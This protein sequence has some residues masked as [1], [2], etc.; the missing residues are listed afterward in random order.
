MCSTNRQLS[1]QT[2]EFNGKFIS[3][4]LSKKIESKKVKIR[5]FS[6]KEKKKKVKIVLCVLSP[7]NLIYNV[8]GNLY[9][10]FFE[11]PQ[12]LNTKYLRNDLKD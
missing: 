6:I 1:H 8:F 12:L 10:S 4:L 2:N 7:C 5:K 9:Y 11:L 3:I